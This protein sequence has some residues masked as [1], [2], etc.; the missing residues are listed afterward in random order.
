M[1][2]YVHAYD[3][4]HDRG[5]T[6]DRHAHATDVRHVLLG[7]DD[8]ISM[9]VERII[10]AV[11]TERTIYTMLVNAHGWEAT[12][13]TPRGIGIVSLSDLADLSDLTAPRFRPL[14][15]YFTHGG[16]ARGVEIHACRILE[17]AGGWRMCQVLADT[18]QVQVAAAEAPQRGIT[19]WWSSTPSDSYGSFEG[20]RQTFMPSTRAE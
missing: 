3:I 5:M 14:Q 20:M 2:V 17:H 16:G 8:S 11:Q 9:I 10:S 19:P 1:I 4:G 12:R 7:R 18:L 15:P 6:W 13:P